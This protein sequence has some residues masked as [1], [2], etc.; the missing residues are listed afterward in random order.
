MA[1]APPCSYAGAIS[2]TRALRFIHP[3]D[4]ER[5][6][7]SAMIPVDDDMSASRIDGTLMCSIFSVSAAKLAMGSIW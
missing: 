2:F 3:R 5:R 4:G 6:L 1:E 7:N